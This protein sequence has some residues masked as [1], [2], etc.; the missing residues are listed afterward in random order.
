MIKGRL[1]DQ[2]LFVSEL[3]VNHILKLAKQSHENYLIKSREKDLEQAIDYYLEAIQMDPSVSEAYCKLA[4]LLWDRG[5]IDI[6]S[7]LEQCEKA[8]KLDPNSST[9]RLYLGYFLK[10][11]GRFEE[12]EKEFI[13]SIKLNFLSAK[14]RIALGSTIVQKMRFTGPSLFALCRGL[15]YFSTGMIMITCDF[16]TIRMLFKSIMED[17]NMLSYK[18]KGTLFKKIKNY[19]QVVKIYENAA[20]KTGKAEMFYSEIGDMSLEIGKPL[21]AIEYYK[22]ALKTSPDNVTLW[23]KLADILQSHYQENVNEI[24]ECYNHIA[25][26]EPN[27]AR[28]Y[29]ELGHLYLRLEDKFSAINAFKRA[30]ELENNNAFYHNSLAYAL[31]QLEDYD[32]ALS[33]YQKAIKLNPDS[34]W[35]SIVSQAVGAIYHQIKDNIDAAIVAYQ[36]ATVLD[37]YNIDAFIALGEAYHDKGDLSN[38]M[39]CYLEAIK[40]DPSNGKTYCN[41]GLVLWER[42][43]V[44]ESIIAYQKALALDTDSETA[45]NNLGVVYLDGAGR[46]EDALAMFTQAI[47]YNPNYALAYY[48]KGRAYQVFGNK[49]EAAKYYQLALDLNKLTEELEEEEV[50]ERIYKLFSVE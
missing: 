46:V 13:E 21:Q 38:S 20:E 36:T 28:V 12:A 50:Q 9:A 48:N 37:S 25:E 5:R 26:L 47:K 6:N 44:E 42:D 43:Y 49:T 45:F 33:E 24:T 15:Y 2:E 41:L 16:G 18:F 8:I 1:Q 31:V 11:S 17:L 32:G 40:I 23:A 14:P 19:D 10:A 7:A 35:T 3:D 22:S 4:S 27:N 39:E 29:Y 34:E 30:I